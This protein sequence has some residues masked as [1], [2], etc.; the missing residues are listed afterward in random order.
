M[1]PLVS[2]RP[3][4]DDKVIAHEVQLRPWDFRWMYRGLCRG[5]TEDQPSTTRIHMIKAEHVGHEG[6]IGVGIGLFFT[7][8]SPFLKGIS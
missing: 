7:F 8:A 4:L 5:Q 6:A 1:N 2:E 3:H